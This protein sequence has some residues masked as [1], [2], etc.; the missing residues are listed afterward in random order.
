MIAALAPAL[1]RIGKHGWWMCQRDG[2]SLYPFSGRAGWRW[3]TTKP[4]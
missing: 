3:V 1:L 4:T 2:E